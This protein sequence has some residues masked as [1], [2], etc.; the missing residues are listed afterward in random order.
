M[1]CVYKAFDRAL[2]RYVAIK[3]LSEQ[4]SQRKDLIERFLREAR[5]V[6][7]LN[8]QNICDIYYLGMDKSKN[9]APFYAME[10]V[11]GEN[12]SQLIE[13]NGPVSL[14]QS[15]KVVLQTAT[16]LSV[17]HSKGM[18]HRDI[19]PENIMLTKDGVVKVT[20]FGLA[21]LLEGGQNLTQSNVIMG[22]P[23][24]MSPEAAKG[25]ACD[26]RSDIYSLG[27]TLFQVLTGR[28]PFKGPSAMSVLQK[29]LNEKVPSASD[30]RKSVPPEVSSLIQRMM[31]KSKEDRHENYEKLI[32]ELRTLLKGC[33]G[34]GK[35]NT[36]AMSAVQGDS[37][38]SDGS[39]GPSDGSP[40]PG[41][42][43]PSPGDGSPGPGDGSPGPSDGSPGPGGASDSLKLDTQVKK[44]LNLKPRISL[45]RRW[46]LKLFLS[47]LIILFAWHFFF[48]YP[49]MVYVEPGKYLVGEVD[50]LRAVE[51]QGFYIDKYEISNS[52]YSK[53]L[54]EKEPE[55]SISALPKIIRNDD[56]IALYLEATGYELP[57]EE[58]WQAAARGRT[59]QAFPWGQSVEDE[60]FDGKVACSATDLDGPAEGGSYSFDYSPSGCYD[61]AGNLREAVRAKDGP[62]EGNNCFDNVLGA[63]YRS[64]L[65]PD[66][67]AYEDGSYRGV[68]KFYRDDLGFR[69]VFNPGLFTR[70]L[71]YI[72]F[73]FTIALI[74]AL[75]LFL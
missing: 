69:G 48:R 20:D 3:E 53:A 42:G 18:I 43:S 16:A 62:I 25:E 45:R 13:R 32:E 39:P 30:I 34:K 17:A 54:G 58:Q 11:D 74:V 37:G 51:L 23:H 70:I 8:H 10:Y 60:D 41:D 75:A 72:Q 14:E 65:R 31:A 71:D 7:K 15:L 26:F 44:I 68:E 50:N 40:S 36:S 4:F 66:S 67:C 38:P 22:T 56:E 9:N 57:T 2:H 24:Y 27:A 6:A 19:K 12:L 55:S 73:A 52:M 46:K 35:T 29:H 5:L 47:L 59:G 64:A 49:S 28:Q 21:K 1:G 63:S 61:M 33:K